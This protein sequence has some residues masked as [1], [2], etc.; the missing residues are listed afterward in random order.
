MFKA[1]KLFKA[2][3]MMEKENASIMG[4]D[5]GSGDAQQ[6]VSPQLTGH[7]TTAATMTI[8]SFGHTYPFCDPKY[9]RY[10]IN[11]YDSRYDVRVES[12]GLTGEQRQ[13]L[14][15]RKGYDEY[16]PRYRPYPSERDARY[17]SNIK[18]W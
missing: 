7:S 3:P 13:V 17:R 1:K 11:R 16:D 15:P 5:L 14:I 10:E 12:C 6:Y 4:V 2:K 8:N 9:I 18:R